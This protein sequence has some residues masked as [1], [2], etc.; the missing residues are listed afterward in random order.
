QRGQVARLVVAELLPHRDREGQAGPPLLEPVEG[1]DRL[2][3]PLRHIHPGKKYITGPAFSGRWRPVRG[4][5]RAGR[6]GPGWPGSAS[7]RIRTLRIR[8][9]SPPRWPGCW[10]RRSPA[11]RWPHPRALGGGFGAELGAARHDHGG[12]VGVGAAADPA[13]VHEVVRPG[14]VSGGPDDPLRADVVA[15]GLA[16]RAL[17][18]AE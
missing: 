7:G 1:P 4:P 12:P 8:T 11:R 13:G 3:R 2:L 16:V 18:P 14:Q 5:G 10:A 6:T 15:P 9:G 17:V